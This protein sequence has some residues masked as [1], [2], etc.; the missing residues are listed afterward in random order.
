V[1]GCVGEG[2]S[3]CERLSDLE[4]SAASGGGYELSKKESYLCLAPIHTFR[5]P[6]MGKTGCRVDEL[7]TWD[8]WWT[9]DKLTKPA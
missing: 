9:G 8:G 3:E 5:T 1:S 2:G 4:L 7:D 6:M